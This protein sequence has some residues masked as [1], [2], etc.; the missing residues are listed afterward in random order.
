[1][2]HSFSHPGV[3]AKNIVRVGFGIGLALVGVAQYQNIGDFAEAV[4]YGLLWL[5]PIGMLWGYILPALFIV[6][7]VLLALGLY[8]VAA[9][10]LAGV[11]L[12]SIPV[13]LTLKSVMLGSPLSTT[14]PTSMTVSIGILVYLVAVRG[15]QSA[16]CVC[17]IPGKHPTVPTIVKP[18]AAPSKAPAS[19]LIAKKS[20]AKK[21]K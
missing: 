4:G 14:I 10:A 16:N 15:L 20:P 2:H 3:V 8:P 19:K 7:G 12:M 5:E 1:M 6:G 17:D 21:K 18:T 11:G 13:G 9:T